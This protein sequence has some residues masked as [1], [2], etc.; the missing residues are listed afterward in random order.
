MLQDP[1]GEIEDAQAQRDLGAV[2]F[3]IFQGARAE[4]ATRYEAFIVIFSWFRAMFSQT[5]AEGDE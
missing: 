4:G 5:A 1:L 2:A 3:R